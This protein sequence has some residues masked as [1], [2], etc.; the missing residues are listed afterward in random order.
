MIA[1][2]MHIGSSKLQLNMTKY[3]TQYTEKVTHRYMGGQILAL[4]I[5]LGLG[6][7]G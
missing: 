1:K 3:G 2:E 7:R 6:E 4:F 5:G